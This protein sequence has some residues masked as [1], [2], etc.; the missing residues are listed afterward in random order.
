[1]FHCWL[2]AATN[3]L[4]SSPLLG[5][6]TSSDEDLDNDLRQGIDN[7]MYVR[8]LHFLHE[9]TNP[10]RSPT[11][12]A[13]SPSTNIQSMFL[14]SIHVRDGLSGHYPMLIYR[15]SILYSALHPPISLLFS[16]SLLTV[17][18]MSRFLPLNA[19]LLP[20]LDL[21]P[22]FT[23]TANSNDLVHFRQVL[24]Q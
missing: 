21:G 11:M 8:F 22:S 6:S 19:N 15:L 24:D 16:R 23:Q 14:N 1:M 17:D 3:H 18:H 20:D 7:I 2:L 9:P 5:V 13:S 4:P 10:P 12:H